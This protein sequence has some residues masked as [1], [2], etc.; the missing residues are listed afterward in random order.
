V[1]IRICEKR[2]KLLDTS[3]HALVTGGPGSGKTTLALL[4]A[5]RRIEIGLDEGQSV[6][7]LSFS[8][9][10][11]ARIAEAATNRLRK[12]HRKLLNI[13]TFHSFFWEILRA[14]GYLIGCPKRLTL[15]APHDERAM[16]DGIVRNDDDPAWQAWKTERE[17]LFR[18][19]GRTAFDLFAPKAAELLAGSRSIRG[20]FGNRHPLIIV[21]EAQDTGPDQWACVKALADFSQ[22]VCL[23]DSD[24]QIFDWLPGIGPERIQQ[25]EAD[26]HP[27]RIDLGSE[28]NRNPNSEIAAF[29]NDILTGAT[30]NAPYKGISTFQFHPRADRRDSA[31]RQSVGVIRKIVEKETGK[32]PESIAM[33][34]SFDRGAVIIS[35]A[36]REGTPPIPH[37]VLFDEAAA[38]LSSRFVAF[39]MEPKHAADYKHDLSEAFLLLSNIFR[40]KGGTGALKRSKELQLWA[41]Q[42]RAERAPTK[43]GYRRVAGLIEGLRR[44]SFCGEPHKDW[45]LIRDILRQTGDK[46]L[47]AVDR[48]L[49]YLMAFNRGKRI[50]SGLSSAWEEHG[51]YSSARKV[52]DAALAEDQILSGGEDLLGIHV[53]TMHKAKGKEFDAVIIFRCEHSSPFVWPRDPEP[54][55]K[56]RKVLRVAITRARIHTMILNQAFPRCPIL[57]RHQL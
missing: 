49:Q 44:I 28:N 26:M 31:I 34:S 40:A 15:L 20:I 42:T 23:A 19:E 37:K 16:S 30:R 55:R 17:R 32:R 12:D 6:L 24:Q 3:G 48:D 38:L 4:K 36:L 10:A 54:Y 51:N 11:V 53:M 43:A 8:K 2:Q 14:H 33:L 52:L 9:A 5:L 39:L 1:K 35:N 13:Q 18:E 41:L 57:S 46:E 25:I 7:F 21:D 45:L 29:G 47:M 56:S 22:V 50:A 27:L